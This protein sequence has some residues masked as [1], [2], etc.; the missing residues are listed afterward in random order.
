MNRHLFP[1]GGSAWPDLQK[2][3]GEMTADDA[4]WRG[5][6]VP[7]FVFR[8]DSDT[9]EVGRNA[10]FEFF[11]EN[12]LGRTRAFHSIGR[13]EEEVLD[14]G[15][16]L[17]SAP[18]GAAGA[19]TS[20]G[21]ESIFL[22]MK[23]ARDAWRAGNGERREPL[24]LV[25]PITGHPA[26]D[27]A[28][29]AMDLQIRRAPLRP[30]RRVDVEALSRLTDARTIAIV[31]SAPCFPHGVIDPIAELSELAQAQGLWLHV[32][33]CVGGWLAPF[34]ARIGRPTPAFDFRFPGVRSISADLH[35][36]GFCPKPASTVFYR[37]RDDMQRASFKADAWPSGSFTTS[38][39][40]GTRPGGA[41]A[42]AWAV[43]NHLG[44]AGYED[45]ARRL[46]AMTDAYVAGL[47][48]IDGIVLLAEPDFT[49]V[50]FGSETFDIHA[51]AKHMK[52][53]G[54]VPGLTRDPKGIHAM[55]SMLHE[56]AR[57]AYL[58][59]LSDAVA[60]VRVE[61]S[62]GSGLEARY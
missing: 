6:R 57:E 37:D 9:Y 15:L 42:A 32:D 31:G 4:D 54:W 39:L 21:S 3:M 26:F 14:Y 49:I 50:N 45:A 25:M 55:L 38:T 20:G 60:K 59:D 13:M 7:L 35:K 29:D 24:N 10:Y 17:F 61:G 56:P 33:A 51:V 44:V 12:A 47:R 1:Q 30:D 46:G 11:T 36:F 48:A 28:A 62:D 19:F 40:L 16:D 5:G 27:K 53:R 18:E 8:N 2:R 34:F 52:A 41:V 43:L 22:A 23:A 58:A